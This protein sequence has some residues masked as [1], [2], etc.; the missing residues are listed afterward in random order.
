[1]K[2]GA[3]NT[4]GTIFAYCSIRLPFDCV[5]M[6]KCDYSVSLIINT[7]KEEMGIKFGSNNLDWSH[8]IKN[9]KIKK[10]EGSII[11]TVVRYNLRNNIFKNKKL[12]EGKNVSFTKN[13]SKCR[14]YI[15]LQNFTVLG[16]SE[17]P[18]ILK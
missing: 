17:P 7:I 16:M 11:F 9:P 10:K 2:S 13:L 5:V 4:S 18:V 3:Y 6:G 12:S 15:K 1:M 14:R 8:P